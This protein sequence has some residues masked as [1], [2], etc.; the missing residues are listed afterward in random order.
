MNHQF[1]RFIQLKQAE[2]TIIIFRPLFS[3]F[4][5]SPP[6]KET[7]FMPKN[8]VGLG[9]STILRRGPL[10]VAKRMVWQQEGAIFV[11]RS[12]TT[13]RRRL[14][15]FVDGGLEFYSKHVVFQP[16]KFHTWFNFIIL[17]ELKLPTRSEMARVFLIQKLIPVLGPCLV[18]EVARLTITLLIFHSLP[19]VYTFEKRYKIE[20]KLR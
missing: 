20:G 10:T 16:Q 14:F 8:S 11:C 2:K 9:C 7:F 6:F 5:F 1:K 13:S 15:F 18:F 17:S 4:N 19:K 3:F 12:L